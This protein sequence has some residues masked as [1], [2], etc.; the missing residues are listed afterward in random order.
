MGVQNLNDP[1]GYVL[2]E[3][4]EVVF[5]SGASKVRFFVLAVSANGRFAEVVLTLANGS[6]ETVELVGLGTP[7]TPIEVDLESHGQLQRFRVQDI[8]E[9]YGVA[10]DSFSFTVP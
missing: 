10:Y 9:S 5:P 1:G 6:T 4:L 7:S 2:S 3:P 8:Q